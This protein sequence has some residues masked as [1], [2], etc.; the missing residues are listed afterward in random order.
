[1]ND[2]NAK[3]TPNTPSATEKPA[4]TTTD[5]GLIRVVTT[6]HADRVEIADT[7]K[8]AFVASC[9]TGKA[10]RLAISADSWLLSDREWAEI[11]KV[12]VHWK[13]QQIPNLKFPRGHMANGGSHPW[14]KVVHRGKTERRK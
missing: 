14:R 3:E 5:L 1:M 8:V 6:S 11:V 10:S 2:P 4:D 13:R 12:Y 7:G 9:A